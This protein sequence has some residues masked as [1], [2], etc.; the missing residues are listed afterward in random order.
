MKI[1]EI[2][3]VIF[4]QEVKE[5]HTIKENLLKI[6]DDMKEEYINGVD[7]I[8]K[9]D[10]STSK[11]MNKEYIRYFIPKITPYINNIS[12]QIEAHDCK[13]IDIWYQQYNKNDTHNWHIHGGVNWANIYF[14]ELPE[15]SVSTQFYDVVNKRILKNIDIK[16]GDLI[17]FPANTIHRS[18]KNKTTK[19]K[20]IISF[21]CD[22]DVRLSTEH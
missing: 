5:H 3:T 18:P 2:P 6:F 20:S 8:S 16:E 21:N 19:R 22:F 12:N 15:T 7:I 10:W 4:K 14:V 17:T 11:D 9:T 13:I 1:F